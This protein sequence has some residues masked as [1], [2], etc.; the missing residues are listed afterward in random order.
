[1]FSKN[2]MT[3]K[4]VMKYFNIKIFFLAICF[5]SAGYYQV[6][7]QTSKNENYKV[8]KI[9][10]FQKK[11]NGK[12][13]SLFFLKNGNLSMAITNYG[14]RVVSL[15]V[16][17]KKGN[18]ADIVIGFK[19]ID[20]YLKANAVYHGAMIGRVAGRIKNGTV[21]L[22]G[23]T[24]PLPLNAGKNHL[25][26]GS[27]GFHNQVWEV[28]SYSDTTLVLTYL[29]V[30]GEMGY[31]GNLMTE[32]TYTL[33][34]KNELVMEYKASTDKSTPV[35]LTNHAF[36]NLAGDDGG[37][38]SDHLLKINAD[39]ICPVDEDKM[40]INRK[41]KVK[42]TPF[43]FRKMKTIG[44]GLSFEKF[45]EQLKFAAGYD[46]H[47]VLNKKKKNN[48]TLAATVVEPNS[49]RKMEVF[50][51]APCLHFFSANFF[52]GADTGKSGMPIK[53]R[54]SF[55]METQSYPYA[56]VQNLFP[57]IILNPG[58]H[59]ETK[60]IFRFSVENNLLIPSKK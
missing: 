42:E 56:E 44:Q 24:Y 37:L 25:H 6:C 57:S 59:Y 36:F 22:N 2:R 7:G 13:I 12:N 17:D 8:L 26:G 55:A 33:N 52:N 39:Y 58:E 4:C 41:S 43:D 21:N 5:F 50:T 20:D 47:F 28:K 29:S 11:V 54:E 40:A 31:P 53:Y 49:G 48:I 9:E 38:I 3:G 27:K 1:M 14:A 15:Y 51:L 46:H 18:L 34:G 23:S 60:T 32:V 19:C 10:D 16:P 45:N 35:N 30:D